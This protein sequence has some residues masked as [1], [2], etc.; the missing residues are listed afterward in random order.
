MKRPL[1]ITIGILI[2]LL[3]IVLW[4]YLM[5]YGAPEKPREVFTNLGFTSD[6]NVPTRVV[7]VE[8]IQNQN[9]NLSLT[10]SNLQ[11]LTTRAVAGFGFVQDEAELLRY[12]EKGTG[13]LYEINFKQSSE[14]QISLTTMP[15]IAQAVFSP[16]GTN[17][18]VTSYEGYDKK[19]TLGK[20]DIKNQALSLV[21]LP[22]NVENVSFLDDEFIYFSVETESGTKGYKFDIAQKKQT[23]VFSTVLTEIKVVWGDAQSAI[24]IQTKPSASQEGY[25]YTVKNNSLTPLQARGYGL[26]TLSN[27]T[28][29]IGSRIEKDGYTSTAY[30]LN[31]ETK[32]PILMLPEKCAFNTEKKTSIWCASPLTVPSASYLESWYKGAITSEDYLWYT[33]LVTQSAQ[34]VGDLQKLSGKTIDVEGLTVNQNGTELIFT[35]KIDQTLWLYKITGNN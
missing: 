17:V 22:L 7:N 30:S 35:N 33:D 12:V 26:T 27:N 4:A 1:I 29:T 11:Q 34:L 23:E 6:S 32:Q 2:I 31:T 8:N 9:T 20:L 24:R 18:V 5:V 19:V 10:G 25:L 3:I 16:N 13:H 14:R 21:P 15:K 28:Y